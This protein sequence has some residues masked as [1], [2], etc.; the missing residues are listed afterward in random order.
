MIVGHGLI[1]KAF[2]HSV[3]DSPHHVVFASG[4]SNSSESNPSAYARELDLL[5]QYLAK[6]KTLIYFST[7]SIFDPTK[8]DSLYIRHK[9]KIEKLIH[10]Q[11]DSY[12]M[13]RLPILVGRTDNAST[14]INFLV[15]AIKEKRPI[16]L[17]SNACRH[18]LDIDDVVPLMTPF[19]SDVK[20][21]HIINIPG[22]K[23]ITIPDLVRKIEFVL[24]KK[25]EFSWQNEGACYDVPTNAGEILYVNKENYVDEILQKYFG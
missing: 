1:A 23:K 8:K 14:L 3:F 25:G 7:T 11:A 10:D 13:V 5:T 2:I 22:S 6:N 18:L 12:L 20:T 19:Y 17:H 4:I 15:N 16:Q 9:I 21:Q 24:N